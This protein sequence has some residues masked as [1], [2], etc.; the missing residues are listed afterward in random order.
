VLKRHAIV[1]V[2]T[3]VV[4]GT[5]VAIVAV[6]QAAPGSLPSL[7]PAGTA[8]TY[9]GYL[10]KNSLALDGVACD[11]KF[12]L[13][14][15][16][17]EGMPIAPTLSRPGVVLAKGEFTA[18]LDFGDVFDGTA[19]WL[20][21]AVLCPGDADYETL[22]PRQALHGVPYAQYALKIPLAGTGT[23][24]TAARSDH[25]HGFPSPDYDSGWVAQGLYNTNWTHNVGGD[26][27]NYLIDM[28]CRNP[29]VGIHNDGIGGDDYEF[30]QGEGVYYRFLTS[31]HV[32][33]ARDTYDPWC[34]EIRI[35]I[36]V[37]E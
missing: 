16:A 5:T 4:L 22:A 2:L 3:G 9:Q 30:G 11:F 7:A 32:N 17:S 15:I 10:E 18:E 26:P 33:V 8:F 1:L 19:F 12:D 20:S 36:W 14:D 31:T 24:E 13:Y 6:G 28:Q 34:Q 25:T 23:A 37:V 21:I 29:G 27:D 35:R